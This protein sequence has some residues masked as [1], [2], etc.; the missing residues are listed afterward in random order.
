[1][2]GFLTETVIHTR[3]GEKKGGPEYQIMTNQG[4]CQRANLPAIALGRSI[5]GN[6]VSTGK[7]MKQH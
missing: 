2:T 7:M 1:M 3:S 4:Q 5:D 6:S